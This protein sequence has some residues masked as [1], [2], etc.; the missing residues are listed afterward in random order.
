MT[1]VLK[2]LNMHLYPSPLLLACI[3]QLQNCLHVA[4]HFSLPKTCPNMRVRVKGLVTEKS[5]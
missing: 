2:I 5:K 1:I 3:A 4:I